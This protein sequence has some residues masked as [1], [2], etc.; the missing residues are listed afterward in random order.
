MISKEK[1]IF[2]ACLQCEYLVNK[3]CVVHTFDKHCPILVYTFYDQGWCS[4]Q[5]LDSQKITLENLTLHS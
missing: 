3:E 2:K 1:R 5:E 4:K